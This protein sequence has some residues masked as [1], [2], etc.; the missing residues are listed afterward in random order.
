MT[1]RVGPRAAITTVLALAAMSACGSDERSPDAVE[2]TAVIVAAATTS[3]SG[4]VPATTAPPQMPTTTTTSGPLFD[5]VTPTSADGWR[6]T[7]DTVMGG[8]SS[9]ELTWSDG[10]LIFVG[11]LS[12]A[13][14]GG[15]ASIRSPAIEAPIA[16]NWGARTGIRLQV[17]GD[18]RTWSLELRTADN[19]GGWIRSFPTS[20]AGPT[21]VELTWASFEPVTRF[22]QPRAVLEPL[23]PT[24]IV[25]VALYLVDGVEGP[26]RL[27]VRSIG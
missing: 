5:F 1:M 10:A 26:F 25:T 27:A 17:D 14:G 11:D 15:F 3:T 24:A 2:T 13:N 9:G 18:G 7:N 8:E 6:V 4:A 22:L 19:S 23:D 20:S 21:D 12:L 16:L